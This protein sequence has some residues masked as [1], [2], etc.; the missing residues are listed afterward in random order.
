MNGHEQDG[1]PALPGPDEAPQCVA[2]AK[3]YLSTMGLS[4]SFEHA[5]GLPMATLA[6]SFERF[7]AAI[8]EG[9]FIIDPTYGGH[10]PG[11]GCA[12]GPGGGGGS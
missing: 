12:D 4:M 1:A 8:R 11:C 6:T 2:I 3:V 5:P 9:Q 7:A 10:G